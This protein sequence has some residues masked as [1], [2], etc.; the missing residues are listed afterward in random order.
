MQTTATEKQNSWDQTSYFDFGKYVYL[1]GPLQF[2]D[3]PYIVI[4]NLVYIPNKHQTEVRTRSQQGRT[5]FS[6]LD[7]SPPPGDQTQQYVLLRRV[8]VQ[9][10]P[11][12]LGFNSHSVDGI[13]GYPECA[14]AF[15]TQLVRR[16]CL[17][18]P[19][20]RDRAG[21][22]RPDF[23]VCVEGSVSPFR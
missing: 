6:R 19:I 3:R 9:E 18:P 14:N 11:Q 5:G 2:L 15:P 21:V 16:G 12:E 13:T 10:G 23:S 7:S 4:L 22:I 20:I 1:Q 17:S 8:A